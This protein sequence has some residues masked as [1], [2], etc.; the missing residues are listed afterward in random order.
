MKAEREVDMGATFDYFGRVSHPDL[1]PG[2]AAGSY[3]PIN[4]QQYNNRMLLRNVML[5]HGF[6]PY[7]CEWWHFTLANE[8]YPDTYFN[9]PINSDSVK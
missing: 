1:Q 6:A 3:Q 2:E 9:F 5:K 7:E 4:E 8:P